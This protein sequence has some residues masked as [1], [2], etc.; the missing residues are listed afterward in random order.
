MPKLSRWSSVAL[1]L[2]AAVVV[3]GAPTVLAQE[4]AFDRIAE[5]AAET[6]QLVL[7]DEIVETFQTPEELAAELPGQIAEENPPERIAAQTRAL[8]AL[9]LLPE[10]TNLLQIYTDLYTEQVAGY[11]DPETD[12]MVIVGDGS[13]EELDAIEEVAYFHETIHALQDQHLGLEAIFDGHEERSDDEVMAITSLIEGDAMVAELD[14]MADNPLLAMR[15]ALQAG[16]QIGAMSTLDEV[17]P[18]LAIGLYFPYVTGLTFVEAIRDAGGWDAVDAAYADLPTSTEQI[19]HPER[20]LER[21]E[22]TPI[23][24]PQPAAALGAGWELVQ[25][26]TAGELDTSILLA[27][28]A[29]GEGFNA[30]TGSF[31]LPEAAT[32]AASGWDGDRYALWGSANQEVLVW[33]S[34]WDSD[35]DAAAFARALQQRDEV[36]F[37]GGWE[38]ETSDDA[39]LMTDDRFVRLVRDGTHVNY[40]LAPTLE[41]ADAA[42]AAL[43][44]G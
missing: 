16:E 14:Y 34:A 35:D 19:L 40:V 38:G 4:E 17:P 43:R 24:L 1:P 8:V 12:Q 39:A 29:P 27:N 22:P 20:Y 6:R 13:G 18:A 32:N 11:Y 7:L 28:L 15:Y 37:G 33:R 23:T 10:G 31:D 25:E 36:R 9:G 3:A 41:L 5:E 2:V 30:L 44:T 42:I 21:D 26:N